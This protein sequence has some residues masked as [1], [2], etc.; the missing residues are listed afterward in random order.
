MGSFP[1]FSFVSLP[2]T[3]PA[4]QVGAAAS[5]VLDH[6]V[7]PGDDK[8]AVGEGRSLRMGSFR[9]KP[10]TSDVQ[11]LSAFWLLPSAPISALLAPA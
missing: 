9:R 7:M 3:D 6:R 4:I 5:A 1:R 2:G 8:R 10:G 11:P